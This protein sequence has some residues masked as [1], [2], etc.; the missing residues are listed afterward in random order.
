[1]NIFKKCVRIECLKKVVKM[2]HGPLYDYF[3]LLVVRSPFW[4]ISLS[5]YFW[6]DHAVSALVEDAPAPLW[7][8]PGF[9]M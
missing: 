5:M 8:Q 4:G 9:T 6:S 7:L 2:C 1:M 3:N